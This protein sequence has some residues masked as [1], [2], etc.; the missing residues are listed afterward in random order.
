[1]FLL[2]THFTKKFF[3]FLK[4]NVLLIKDSKQ[5]QDRIQQ[6]IEIIGD[7]FYD[8]K[9]PIYWRKE[10]EKYIAWE[11]ELFNSCSMENMYF[12][13]EYI[14]KNQIPPI[15]LDNV[16][17]VKNSSGGRLLFEFFTDTYAL[18]LLDKKDNGE[19]AENQLKIDKDTEFDVKIAT[20][21]VIQDFKTLKVEVFE[22]IEF[23][24]HKTNLG[25]AYYKVYEAVD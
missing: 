2:I 17:K 7:S 9:P 14:Q 13:D 1:M 11:R 12:L 10:I 5:D 24:N 6:K 20:L 23:K 8:N 25:F 3:A 4:E 15:A 16:K 21:L 18:K 22:V 19:K